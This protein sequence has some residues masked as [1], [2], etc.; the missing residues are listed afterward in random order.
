M[1]P[2]LQRWLMAGA[3][4]AFGAA[5]FA[6]CAQDVG[7]IDR[8]QPDKI[9]KS[10]FKND[11]VWYYRQT[12][13]DVPVQ[14]GG[15]IWPAYQS[16]LKKIRWEVTEDTLY[17]YSTTDPVEGITEDRQGQ[18]DKRLGA[19]AAF[20]IES[21]FDVIRDYSSAT[22]EPSNVIRE[23]R[24][25]RVWYEREYMRVNWST[26][27]VDGR[28]M[29]GSA[30]G[31]LASTTYQPPQQDEHVDPA[32]T[33]ISSDNIDVTTEYVFRPNI[34]S[35][36][37]NL[38]YDSID[39]CDGARIRVRNSFVPVEQLNPDDYEPMNY[40]DRKVIREG[41][42][43]T[44]DPLMTTGYYDNYTRD[45]RSATFQ[46]YTLECDASAEYNGQM[47]STLD[48]LRR[49]EGTTFEGCSPAGF[50]Y[51]GRF[52]YFRTRRT[53]FDRDRPNTEPNK[54]YMANRWDIW[55][56]ANGE[57]HPKPIIF[58]LNAQY[59]KHMFPAAEEVERQWNETMLESVA[60]KL[61]SSADAN[62]NYS[63][64]TPIERNPADG[65]KE[66]MDYAVDAVQRSDTLG[67]A[68]TKPMAGIKT[69]DSGKMFRIKKNAC[70]PGPFTTWLEEFGGEADADRKSP[71]QLVSDAVGSSLTGDALE[72]ALWNLPHEERVQLCADVE[73]ATELRKDGQGRFTYERRGDLRY[74]LFNWVHEYNLGWSGYGPSSADPD[75]GEIVSANANFAGTPLYDSAAYGADLVKFMNGELNKQEVIY[76]SHIDRSIRQA[77]RQQGQALE[78]FNSDT[79]DEA[80]DRDL[81]RSADD[82]NFAED[83][84]T[85]ADMPDSVQRL[86]IDQMQRK[87]DKAAK[88]AKFARDTT[89]MWSDAFNKPRIKELM[90]QGPNF[91]TT[92][93]LLAQSDPAAI[94]Q[95]GGNTADFSPMDRDVQHQAYMDAVNPAR[96][97]QQQKRSHKWMA[98]NNMLSAQALDR[99]MSGLVT[100][101]GVAEAFEGMERQKLERYLMNNAFI[102]T[103]LH[104]VGHTLGLRHNFNASMDALN[105]HE[106]FWKI[107]RKI[108]QGEV[109][110]GTRGL[111]NGAAEGAQTQYAITD[112][113]L[114]NDIVGE[115]NA[116][117]N[118]DY[119]SAEEFKQASI[120]D[121]T[122]DMTGRFAG[123]GKYDQAA[124][125]F[126]YGGHVQT[127]D[128][129]MVDLTTDFRTAQFI[130]DYSQLPSIMGEIATAS[131]STPEQ[132][133][134]SGIEVILNGRDWTPIDEVIEGQREGIKQTT[135]KWLSGEFEQNNS[136]TPYVQPSISYNFC[137]DYRADYSLGCDTFDHG[138]NHSEVVQHFID[139]YRFYQ[140]FW[141]YRGQKIDPLNNFLRSYMGRVQR[142]M[143]AASRP[144]RYFSIYR[145]LAGFGYDFVQ[146]LRFAGVKGLNFFSEVI[147]KPE[148]GLYCRLHSTEVPGNPDARST[149]DDMT[150]SYYRDA[151]WYYDL[152]NSYVPS[153]WLQQEGDCPNSVQIPRGPGQYYGYDLV[154]EYGTP[155]QRVRRV[156]TYIDKQLAT[157]GMFNISG[158]WIN[159]SFI[160]DSRATRVSFW[161]EYRQR[162]VK[163]IGSTIM[164]D[165]TG[166]GGHIDAEAAGDPDQA[167]Y[168]APQFV[169]PQGFVDDPGD[170]SDTDL[171][172]TMPSLKNDIGFPNQVQTLI[173]SLI[174]NDSYQDQQ[175]DF[176]RYV[177]VS[178]Y[179]SKLPQLGDELPESEKWATF[180][181]P[182][183]NV[184]FA[185]PQ[186][187]D[188]HSIS[189]K[190]IEWANRLGDNYE[191]AVSSGTED[192]TLAREQ[193]EDVVAK[194]KMLREMQSIYTETN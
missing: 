30:L 29:V 80:A 9:K 70:H 125:N 84:K 176:S 149:V 76:G 171:T 18:D 145:S 190:L 58:H 66:M 179:E 56:E 113:Q 155:T 20:P 96:T 170:S 110:E 95:S 162:M 85:I 87:A 136:G 124:I 115:D 64:E 37:Q 17:A 21:H 129:D 91:Q 39:F 143:T 78:A 173:G 156:G 65:D 148:P 77:R 174:L 100:Y 127:W 101:R 163:F 118:V 10:L 177:E 184:T 43:N 49:R 187:T 131:S 111:D 89:S 40:P 121:Y 103:Q 193:L 2:Q 38:G 133:Q 93:E 71:R 19:V 79:T 119:L 60:L 147:A 122:A 151:D 25:D 123:L 61:R 94:S 102:G 117:E 11:K 32:R 33:R 22:G 13:T 191:N 167:V 28:G 5:I 169:E 6:G 186:L 50:S 168:Q 142:T 106:G 128:D 182:I 86:G 161:S 34:M 108:I 126:V 189:V 180:T 12:V 175:V 120:M 83:I 52:G 153:W 183:T 132:E 26:N 73:W 27:L 137:S 81:R 74:S 146:D 42:G 44:G 157:F 92:V 194:L 63:S 24:S 7:D 141:R 134:L 158:N 105:Y 1:R 154:N 88:A 82:F 16:S 112:D 36:F 54:K 109:E 98:E 55:R 45:N 14:G 15:T 150:G 138:A 35:C 47:T 166:F 46:S 140:P 160:T 114:I 90:M 152:S 188:G 68:N 192:A 75:T 23:D 62:D 67:I 139:Q 53:Q 116:A 164:G 104:E 69:D 41:E 181:H 8:T 59:P 107:Q 135:D 3:L 159:S 4:L 172:E 130:N 31:T 144:F 97:L 57:R 48:I 178:I 185:A 99:A 72:E 165:F 51:F